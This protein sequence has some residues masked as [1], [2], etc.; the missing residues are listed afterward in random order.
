V[1]QLKKTLTMYFLY[2]FFDLKV[3]QCSGLWDMIHRCSTQEQQPKL[4]F[5]SCM[6]SQMIILNILL[7]LFGVIGSIETYWKHRNLKLLQ[8]VSNMVDQVTDRAI[9]MMDD[10]KLANNPPTT[11]SSSCTSLQ[12]V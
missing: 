1:T 2:G 7:P 8:D 6:F 9:R 4:F 11:S 12:S 3:W 5:S 10:W